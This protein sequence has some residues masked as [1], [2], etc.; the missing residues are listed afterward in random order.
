MLNYGRS[1]VTH[2]YLLGPKVLDGLN[3]ASYVPRNIPSGEFL[4]L[5]RAEPDRLG[6]GHT[7]STICITLI[8]LVN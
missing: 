2:W 5:W 8:R 4:L 7:V 3:L 1:W 6:F